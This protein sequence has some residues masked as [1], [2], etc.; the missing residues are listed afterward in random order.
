MGL[1]EKRATLLRG[2][3]ISKKTDE[4]NYV[5][6][7]HYAYNPY[8]AYSDDYIC[9]LPPKENWLEVRIVAGEM[10]YHD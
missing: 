8:C 3:S 6:D 5:I 2:I 1:P 10:S 9:P 7:F 4:D